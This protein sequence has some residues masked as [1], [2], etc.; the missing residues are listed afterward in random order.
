MSDRKIANFIRIHDAN[1]I[2]TYLVEQVKGRDYSIDDFY[3]MM[4]MYLE[5]PTTF[6]VAI[7]D[8]ERIICGYLWM[9]VD[10]LTMSLYINT[11]S[12]DIEVRLSNSVMDD[13]I[14]Y[15][16]NLGRSIKV[17]K[18]SWHSYKTGLFVKRGFTVINGSLMEYDLK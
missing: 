2:P 16:E 9:V 7:T 6:L 14:K 8:E 10:L 4:P 5:S 17:R 11:A 3:R 18:I 12:V 13:I 1:L 15:V